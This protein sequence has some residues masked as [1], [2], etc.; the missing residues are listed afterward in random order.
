MRRLRLRKV[1]TP[2]LT[3]ARLTV[4]GDA[5][6]KTRCSDTSNAN[7]NRSTMTEHEALV[8]ELHAAVEELVGHVEATA[9]NVVNTPDTRNVTND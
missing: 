5:S 8:V 2:W 4:R 9:E 6:R 1:P 7:L 3:L